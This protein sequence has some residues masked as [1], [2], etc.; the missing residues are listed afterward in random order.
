VLPVWAPGAYE[1][2]ESA[3]EVREVSATLEGSQDPVP[4]LRTAKNRWRLAP[5]SGG[6]ID[7]RYTMYARDL[8]DDGADADATHLY[9]NATRCFPYV[10]GREREPIEVELHL[11]AGWKAFAEL[12]RVSEEPPRFRARDY[13]EL[14]DTPFDAGTPIEIDWSS[15]NVPHHFLLCGGTGNFDVSRLREDLPKVVEAAM[16]YIGDTPLSSY[17]FF[18]HLHNGLRAGLEHKAS[19]SLLANRSM[20][21]PEKSYGEF[22]LLCAHEYFH[23]YNVKRIRP[24]V[25]G[26]FDFTRENYTRLLWLMEGTTDYVALLL[27]RYGGLDLPSK[28]LEKLAQRIRTYSLIPGRLVKSLEEASFTSWVELYKPYEES[29]N[30]A[31]SYYLKGLL[32]SWCLDLEIRHR[33]GGD[34]S[35]ETVFRLLWSEYGKV[36]RGIAEGE[37]QPIFERA[38]GV[39]LGP[40]FDRYIRGTEEIDFL[41]FARYA[42]LSLAPAPREDP[43]KPVPGYLGAELTTD[44]GELRVRSVL[45]CS[46]ARLAGISPEDEIVAID[47]IRVTPTQF[48]DTL[49]SFPPGTR[50]D[51]LLFRRGSALTVPVTFGTPPPEKWNFTPVDNPTELERRIYEGWLRKPWE[52]KAPPARPVEKSSSPAAAVA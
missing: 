9:L 18:T 19:T 8:A 1:I 33:T 46:P 22:L 13:E 35:L 11:P 42:G 29:T 6:T 26:P 7:V 40:F 37:A 50:A 5:A 10:E 2:R 41:P 20:F 27:L 4:V 43:D 32:V 17:T 3:R 31:V 24:A 21:R 39:P 49:G 25:L 52:P 51:V 36:G 47:G 12:P 38:T 28:T 23:L 48:A 44:R 34:R 30:Q 16:A 14:V 45:D 15:R